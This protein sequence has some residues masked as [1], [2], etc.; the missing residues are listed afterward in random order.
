MNKLLLSVKQSQSLVEFKSKSC[1]L[2]RNKLLL[3]NLQLIIS[4][5]IV[6]RVG[7]ISLS[8]LCKFVSMCNYVTKAKQS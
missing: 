8:Y 2:K 1:S 6:T 7:F 5:Q 4:W 3:Q